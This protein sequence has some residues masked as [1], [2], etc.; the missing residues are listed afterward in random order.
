MP[1]DTIPR[2][3]VLFGD[4]SNTLLGSG[5]I[6]ST[7]KDINPVNS[8]SFITNSSN[9]GTTNTLWANGSKLYLGTNAV[10]PITLGAV[11]S[12]P[13]ANAATLAAGV[14]NLQPADAANPGVITAGT[15]TFGGAKT[16]NGAIICAPIQSTNAISGSRTVTISPDGTLTSFLPCN[17]MAL[18][19]IPDG[20]SAIGSDAPL[21]L[22]TI[23]SPG[24]TGISV[25]SNNI[26]LTR[27]GN[28]LLIIG[29][30][31][32]TPLP[33]NAANLYIQMRV[34]STP[35]ASDLAVQSGQVC[36]QIQL[37]NV[38]NPYHFHYTIQKTTDTST[39]NYVSFISRGDS[40]PTAGTAPAWTG[41]N[42]VQCLFNATPAF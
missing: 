22:G 13:N 37:P 9:P 5:V 8:V 17:Q 7:A 23:P 38:D 20:T 18:L 10:G 30:N 4:D 33:P 35:G 15:Q 19:S 36:G 41:A 34:G 25:S 26:V 12:G 32:K 14:L 6:V 42:F 39:P 3:I 31:M 21:A 40:V 29:L 16:F 24:T 2:E 11:G 28:Y 27:P 1:T